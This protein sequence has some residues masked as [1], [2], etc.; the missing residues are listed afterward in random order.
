MADTILQTAEDLQIVP[1]TKQLALHQAESILT[2]EHNWTE[3][4]DEPWNLGNIMYE[5]LGKW[6]LSH[7]ALNHGGV[8][9]YQIGSIREGHAFLNKIIV[10][11][12]K[13]V[14]SAGRGLLRAFLNESLKKGIERV[15]FR[16]R[17]D[18]PAVGFYE[19]LGFVPKR[20]L[21]YSRK[22]GVASYFYDTRIMDVIQNM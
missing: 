15:M 19:K 9:G 13:R 7:I 4:G 20:E 17:V 8:I 18:N 11:R 21:D 2:L 16:V 14:K 12:K 3:I 6:E 22:D 5:L 1:L 10:D